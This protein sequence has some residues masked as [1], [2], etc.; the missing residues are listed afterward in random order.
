[1]I[2]CVIKRYLK[3]EAQLTQRLV[4]AGVP[5][6]LCRWIFRAIKLAAVGLF[7]YVSFW[8]AIAVVGLWVLS[9]MLALGSMPIGT[10]EEK[11]GWRNGRAGFGLYCGGQR[12]NTGFDDE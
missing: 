11:N 9:E 7:L 4:T 3:W 10:D 2:G 12:I 6:T 1:L 8:I 5:A